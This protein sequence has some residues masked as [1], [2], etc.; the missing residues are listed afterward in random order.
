MKRWF[1]LIVFIVVFNL[2]LVNSVLVSKD[3]VKQVTKE[4]N[5]GKLMGFG[6]DS[7][8]KLVNAVVIRGANGKVEV[9][10]NGNGDI[11]LANEKIFRNDNGA[12]LFDSNSPARFVFQNGK[13]IEASFKVQEGLKVNEESSFNLF[14]NGHSFMVPASGQVDFKDG[15]ITVVSNEDL[16]TAMSPAFHIDNSFFPLVIDYVANGKET[17]FDIFGAAIVPLK[18][19]TLRY[20]FNT[21]SSDP[22]IIGE[23]VVFGDFNGPLNSGTEIVLSNMEIKNVK[24]E[25]GFRISTF[26]GSPDKDPSVP[27]LSIRNI[28]MGKVAIPACVVCEEQKD[29][30]YGMNLK[31]YEKGAF[32]EIRADES[33]NAPQF[34]FNSG[35]NFFADLKE[36]QTLTL[37][38]G[39]EKTRV[40]STWNPGLNGERAE[41]IIAYSA[42]T[43]IN[44]FGNVYEVRKEDGKYEWYGSRD[45]F[46]NQYPVK[47]VSSD[48]VVSVKN[49]GSSVNRF[50]LD[51]IETISDKVGNFFKQDPL[52]INN[53]LR[54]IFGYSQKN[55]KFIPPNAPVAP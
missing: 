8:V 16:K 47:L 34:T 15:K 54:R 4:E 55:Y 36:G 1:F 46:P 41:Y 19:G 38:P 23:K 3:E 26:E 21:K 10:L 52:N 33:G 53:A 13:L 39:F 44:N 20:D 25:I 2:F 42:G 9:N 7:D 28:D 43:K 11:V 5:V 22:Y 50:M 30:F 37:T 14:I 32:I 49:Q 24:P 29:Y 40:Y 12:M 45:P 17:P 27:Y 31:S 6:Y 48:Y 35:N 51:S 18:D